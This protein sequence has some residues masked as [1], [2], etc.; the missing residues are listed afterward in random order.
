MAKKGNKKSKCKFKYCITTTIMLHLL[1]ELEH[2]N[3]L[4]MNLKQ[5]HEFV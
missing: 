3:R 1:Q 2:F 4:N 5:H